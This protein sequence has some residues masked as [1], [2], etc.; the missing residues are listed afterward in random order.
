MSLDLVSLIEPVARELLGEPNVRLSSKR[1]LRFGSRGSMTVDLRKG[2]WFDHEQGRGGGVLDLVERQTGLQGRDRFEWVEE[3]G[4]TNSQRGKL[5]EPRRS[6]KYR[7]PNEAGRIA[8]AL[9][10]WGEAEPLKGTLGIIYLEHER[11]IFELPPDVHEVLRF[12]PRCIYG[13]DDSGW[14]YRACILALYRD[15]V[16][17][18]PTGVH[19]IALSEEGELIGRKALG[20]KQGSAI[21]LWGDASVTTALVIGEGIETVL[22]AAT[23]VHYRGTLLQPAWSLIDAGNL[24][25]FPLLDGIEHLTVLTDNDHAD[26]KGRRA[27]QDA[28]RTCVRRWRATGREAVALIPDKLGE[29]FND[30]ARRVP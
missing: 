18:E 17:D 4:L 25:N 15:I 8:S 29:D 28:A 2:T 6:E 27:G 7:E 22:S 24:V 10:W 19:R 1:E 5:V 3:H 11:E 14:Q 23:R 21:K 9:C 20:K 26:K 30:I 12:H 16:T 13:Q